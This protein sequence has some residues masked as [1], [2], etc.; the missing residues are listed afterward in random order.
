MREGDSGGKIP[1]VESDGENTFAGERRHAIRVSPIFRLAL[2]LLSVAFT[3][4]P[5]RL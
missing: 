2:I 3:T 4:V 5:L 1:E